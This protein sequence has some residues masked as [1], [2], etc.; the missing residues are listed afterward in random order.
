MLAD[1]ISIDFKEPQIDISEVWNPLQEAY[2]VIIKC[3]VER[4]S[5]F[6]LLPELEKFSATMRGD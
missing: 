1:Y 2:M 3:S 6:E 4:S 5:L